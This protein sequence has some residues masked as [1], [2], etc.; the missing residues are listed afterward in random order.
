MAECRLRVADLY[1][2]DSVA[3]FLEGNKCMETDVA[4]VC[5]VYVPL[6][7]ALVIVFGM[8]PTLMFQRSMPESMQ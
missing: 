1:D 3:D 2:A 8:W 4:Q 6:D 5:V 7:L